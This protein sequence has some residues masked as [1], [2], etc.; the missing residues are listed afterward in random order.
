MLLEARV[1]VALHAEGAPAAP[2][3]SSLEWK[4]TLS[5]GDRCN[6]VV[7]HVASPVPPSPPLWSSS[8][9]SLVFVDEMIADS[10]LRLD[11]GGGGGGAAAVAEAPLPPPSPPPFCLRLFFFFA[12]VSSDW[13]W[14]P[15][16]CSS[17]TRCS[18]S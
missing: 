4:M 13:A 7:E 15:C 12:V 1:S 11:S 9:S 5:L 2:A 17:A 8:S 14:G 16:S 6:S 18:W 10:G 3:S